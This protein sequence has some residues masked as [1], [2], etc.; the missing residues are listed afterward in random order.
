MFLASSVIAQ[1]V[2]PQ[3]VYFDFEGNKV[4]STRA[5]REVAGDC[6]TQ[7]SDSRGRYESDELDWCLGKIRLFLIGKAYLRA[8][9]GKPRQEQTESGLRLIIP[10]EEGLR[11]RLGDINIQ[12]ARLFSPDQIVGML[13]LKPGDLASGEVLSDWLAQKLKQAYA[14]RGY[15]QFTYELEPHFRPIAS[16]E[17][18]G[19]V[20]LSVSIEEGR[21]FTI[22]RIIFRGNSHTADELL[23][24]ALLL[25][26]GDTFSQ[27]LFD[28]SI[29]KLNQLGLFEEINGSS[30]VEWE[31]PRNGAPEMDLI[32]H[33]KERESVS[34]IATF[35]RQ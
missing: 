33:L 14:N 32:F 19:I 4:F 26:E 34:Y 8:T 35:Q 18:E 6:V 31:A 11:Y 2:A 29:K 23:L 21:V 30:D 24:S 3:K 13:G 25:R 20:D 22:R 7:R 17:S 1:E 27:Q 9:V 28:D 16:T 10:V 12:G 5:L 15:I